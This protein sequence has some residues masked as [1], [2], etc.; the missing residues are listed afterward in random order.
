[1]KTMKQNVWV[2]MLSV[3][4]SLTLICGLLP[5]INV[6]ATDGDGWIQANNYTQLVKGKDYDYSF[7][8]LGDIQHITDYTPDD[9]HYLF[10]YIINRENEEW[11]FIR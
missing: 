5:A 11:D 3:L 9:L 1:M 10:D 8:V 6:W 7:A 2:R 4:L